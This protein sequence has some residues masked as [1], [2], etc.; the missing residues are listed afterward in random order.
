MQSQVLPLL[1]REED[2]RYTPYYDSLGFPTTGMGFR[3][4]DA[5]EPLPDFKIGDATI[6]AWANELLDKIYLDMADY[7]EITDA[8]CN[9]N[10]P[11]QDILTS[12]AYQMGVSGLSKFHHMLQAVAAHDWNEAA[13]QML[14]STWA[15]QTPERANRHAAVMRSGRWHPTYDF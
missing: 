15:T 13:K 4:A 6:D 11:R 8:M 9:C 2:V 14:D 1:R 12:M 7:D 5:G 3:L 10:Q